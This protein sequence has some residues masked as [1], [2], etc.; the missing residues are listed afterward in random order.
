MP[1]RC[2]EVLFSPTSDCNLSCP[3][4]NSA[5]TK[6][7]LSIKSAKKFL[8]SCK[9][10]G[11]KRIG[12]TGGE[13]F[14]APAFLFSITEFAVR[15]GFLFT[16][17]MT[18]GVWYKD[19]ARLRAILEKL[20]SAGYD[21]SISISVDAY[22]AQSLKRIAYF[23]DSVVS[24]WRRPDMVSIFYVTGRDT[25]TKNKLSKLAGLLKA[26]LA[27]SFPRKRES[28]NLS[29]RKRGTGNENPFPCHPR[30]FVIPRPCH[31]RE[32]GNP[33]T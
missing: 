23:I 33:E 8:K 4:C 17:I 28:I 3:H 18:N 10:N 24:I 31:S 29:S 21:G 14:L 13:P 12:F 11:I 1:F 26:R 9:E 19:K 2:E 6:N 32:S 16:T 27:L 22:H 20:F 7:K 15:Q 25:Q 5:K 30:P